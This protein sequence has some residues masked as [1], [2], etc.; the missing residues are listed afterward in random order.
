M[1]DRSP[2][3]FITLRDQYNLELVTE[4]Y[5]AHYWRPRLEEGEVRIGYVCTEGSGE[6]PT[7]EDL[8]RLS[9]APTV[10]RDTK[11]VTAKSA[12]LAKPGR[13]ERLFPVANPSKGQLTIYRPVP[14]SADYVALSDVAVLHDPDAAN[15]PDPHFRCVHK[16]LVKHSELLSP[17]IWKDREST[18]NI[19]GSGFFL[20]TGSES[21]PDDQHPY[22]LNAGSI[23]SNLR[24][25]ITTTTAGPIEW[26]P[27]SVKRTNYNNTSD[28][29]TTY[30]FDVTKMRSRTV[31]GTWTS[32]S[33]TELGFKLGVSAEVATEVNTGVV[34]TGV[35]MTTSFES[36]ISHTEFA[37]IGGGTTDLESTAFRQVCTVQVPAKTNV[38]VEALFYRANYDVTYDGELVLDSG[39]PGSTPIVV[40]VKGTFSYSVPTEETWWNVT[41]GTFVEKHALPTSG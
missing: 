14:P 13:W 35:K 7:K 9:A 37:Q 32:G 28:R 40:S 33:S 10:V 30:V 31:T 21:Y 3:E 12:V 5:D 4:Y 16:A 20:W 18:W 2:V 19:Q 8:K 22:V 11:R 36:A 25:K 29:E 24:P 23:L 39:A 1:S 15:D 41:N 17:C 26:I 27:E 34:K 6:P 38:E